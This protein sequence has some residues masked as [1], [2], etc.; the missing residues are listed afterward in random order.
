MNPKHWQPLPPSGEVDI[1]I[2]WARPYGAQD[3]QTA[4]YLFHRAYPQAVAYIE[5]QAP[6]NR[7]PASLPWDGLPLGQ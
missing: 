4:M 3:V 1:G 5:Q 6:E 2:D 7:P